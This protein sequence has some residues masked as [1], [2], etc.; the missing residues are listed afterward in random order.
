MG[1]HKLP[2]IIII[3]RKQFDVIHGSSWSKHIKAHERLRRFDVRYSALRLIGKT[4]VYIPQTT[5]SRT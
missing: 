2:I 5:H 4:S 3:Y 1:R